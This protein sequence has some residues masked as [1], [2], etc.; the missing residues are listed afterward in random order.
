MNRTEHLLSIVVEECAEVALRC[1]KAMRFG[2][3]DAEPGQ[4]FTN[5]QRICAEYNDLVAV[6][7]MLNDELG[8]PDLL[9]SQWRQA[10]SVKKSKLKFLL[11]SRECG[12][13]TDC[14]Q[15]NDK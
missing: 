5:A 11:Y 7:E 6:L 3:D 12:T 14:A 13:L 8:L 1:S 10:I 9:H 2:L 4:K 15:Y